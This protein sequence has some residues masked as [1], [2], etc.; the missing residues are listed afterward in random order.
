MAEPAITT[1]IPTRDRA[2]VIGQTLRSILAQRDVDAR[3][4]IVDDASTDGT[5]E[6]LRR[7]EG[8]RVKVIRH[9]EAVGPAIGRNHGAAAADTDLIAFCDDDDIWAP[10]KLARQV[11]AMAAMPAARWSCTGAIT[12]DPVGRVVGHHRLGPDGDILER[13]LGTDVIPGGASSVL[14]QRSL[15]DEVGGF[16]PSIIS[17][18]DWELYIRLADRSPIAGVDAP[19]VAYRVWPGSM[20]WDV[21]KMER[22][23]HQTVARHS[24]HPFGSPERTEADESFDRYMARMELRN[25]QRVAVARRHVRMARR[26]RRPKDLVHSLISL[27]AP[28]TTERWRARHE[29]AQVPREWIA[30]VESWLPPLLRDDLA[31]SLDV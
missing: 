10:T 6:L 2:G 20:S 11:A 9:L 22:A 1:I 28:R 19:L 23:Y 29:L 5:S 13:I 18:Q 31:H 17:A 25:G 21:S 14:M 26:L 4:V 12:I 3:L 7:L 27:A 8:D 30:D 15:F 16:D 24:P